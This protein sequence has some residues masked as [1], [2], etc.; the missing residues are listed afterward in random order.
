MGNLGFTHPHACINCARVRGGQLESW[1]KFIDELEALPD[2]FKV[3]GINDYLFIDGYKYLKQEQD[4][5]G[6]LPGRTLLPVLEFR[7]DALVGAA[8][9]KKI[10]YH[11]IF[12][13]EIPSDEIE[14]A[15]IQ[16]LKLPDGLPLTKVNL[17]NC[18]KRLKDGVPPDKVLNVTN[19]QYGF[20]NFEI[21]KDEFFRLLRSI[22]SWT[23][24]YITAVGKLEW[25]EMR[26]DSAPELKKGFINTADFV[27]CA[28]PTVEKI[29]SHVGALNSEGINSK[30][31]HCSD[32]HKY[33]SNPTEPGRLGHCFTWIQAEPTFEGLRQT[34]FAYESRVHFGT[35]PPPAPIHQMKHVEF[36]F[37][38][39][40]KY[41]SS[42]Q[43]APF[44]LSGSEL[45]INFH[46]GLTCLIGGRGSGKSTILETIASRFEPDKIG[47]LEHLK[48][49]PE[50]D[51]D[52]LL[53][54]DDHSLS[55][56][57]VYIAQNHISDLAA[58]P[59]RLTKII[60]ESLK[61][62]SEL[63]LK[64]GLIRDGVKGL[65]AADNIIL[66][67]I[68]V[69]REIWTITESIKSDKSIA[70]KLVSLGIEKQQKSVSE[71]SAILAG[72]ESAEKR[73]K[74]LIRGI[75]ELKAEFSPPCEA[76]N[77]WDQ[78]VNSILAQLEKLDLDS[79][80][81]T[82][83][84]ALQEVE[85]AKEERDKVLEILQQ[86]LVEISISEEDISDIKKAQ[87]NLSTREHMLTDLQKTKAKLEAT[88]ESTPAL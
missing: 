77:L 62:P 73:Y 43:D 30:L 25:D 71:R 54:F 5:N 1:E 8:S 75:N 59:S 67:L 72:L 76:E 69:E 61:K 38:E 17:E 56:N 21:K 48:G 29:I 27:F 74:R 45:T 7:L 58:Q 78:L 87:E 19:L 41:N 42:D 49:L 81:L 83:K 13:P 36:K 10:N 6:R 63:V 33:T 35:T 16:Q 68:D 18:G 26:W 66:S 51:L 65:A 88:L 57:P 44:C 20:N 34:L 28:S 11:V 39:G 31:L 52:Q 4:C 86:K 40:L 14:Q 23:D 46:S 22:P 64:E 80:D 60:H 24:K 2:S 85:T 55:A 84:A 3:L 47:E 53:S 70:S 9:T 32:A 12:S 79:S 37:P 82:R 15:F 50:L